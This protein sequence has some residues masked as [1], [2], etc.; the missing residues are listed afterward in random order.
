[1]GHLS[2]FEFQVTHVGETESCRGIFDDGRAPAATQTTIRFRMANS[3]ALLVVVVQVLI[4][5]I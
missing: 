2:P 3:K 4:C 5:R 1:M